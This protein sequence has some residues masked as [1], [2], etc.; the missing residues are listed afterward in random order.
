MP[1]DMRQSPSLGIRPRLPVAIRW[2]DGEPKIIAGGVPVVPFNTALRY[3]ARNEG[4]TRKSL[5]G[6]ARAGALYSTYCAHQQVGL[7][8]VANEEFPTFIDGLLGLKFRSASGE[9]VHL[10][11][12]VRSRGSA[13]LFVTLLYSLTGDVAHLYDVSF[14]WRRYRRVVGSGGGLTAVARAHLLT[15]L[16]QRV[17]RIRHTARK[18]VGLPDQEFEK[19]LRRAVELWGE[20]LAPGD[21]R[22]ALEPERQR[23][24]LLH[25]NVAI[26]LCMRYAGARR[27]EVT[28]IRIDQVHQQDHHLELETKGHR[29]GDV[30]YLPVV[31][32]PEVAEQLWRYFTEYRPVVSNTTDQGLFLSHG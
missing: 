1:L 6:Y 25:R 19:M 20:Y 17:H 14:D 24:A 2:V 11:G 31:L 4:A 27:S 21:R 26:L 28:P 16:G 23:G 18:V 22:F 8:D 5:A 12:R 13:D 9:L 7:L 30:E 15:G 3:R 10:D 32:Y 29:K